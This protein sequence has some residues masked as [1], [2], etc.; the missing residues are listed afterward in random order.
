M[1]TLDSATQTINVLSVKFDYFLIHQFKHVL[2]CG[3]VRNGEAFF[4]STQ[5][6]SKFIVNKGVSVGK[7]FAAAS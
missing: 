4:L 7:L 5:D 3:E 2:W 6:K 1:L